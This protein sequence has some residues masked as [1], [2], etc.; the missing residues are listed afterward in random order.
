ML[1]PSFFGRLSSKLSGDY[2]PVVEATRCRD[3]SFGFEAAHNPSYSMR[4]DVQNRGIFLLDRS[5][6]LG[7]N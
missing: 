2:S 1:H 3:E 4:N 5:G 7:Q 6:L